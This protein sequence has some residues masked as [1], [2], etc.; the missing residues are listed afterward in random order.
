MKSEA[1]ENEQA[2]V[3][4]VRGEVALK[5]LTQRMHGTLGFWLGFIFA[6][7]PNDL[8]ALRKRLERQFSDEARRMT[9]LTPGKPA[10][11]ASLVNRLLEDRALSQADCV[12]I[13]ALTVEAP[14]AREAPWTG[15]WE[16]LIQ[17]LEAQLD[18][19][20]RTLSGPLL[21]AAPPSLIDPCPRWGPDLWSA[22]ALALRIDPQNVQRG[23]PTGPPPLPRGSQSAFQA[24]T[25]PDPDEI[26]KLARD[27]QWA[28]EWAA[29]RSSR[30]PG[31][32]RASVPGM[33]RISALPGSTFEPAPESGAINIAR[34]GAH[35]D[36]AEGFLEQGRLQDAKEAAEEAYATLRGRE[37]PEEAR[38]L[39]VLAKVEHTLGNRERAEANVQK[40]ITWRATASG[41]VPTEWYAL[42]AKLACERSDFNAAAE[43]ED[44][45]F[46]A[47]L[48]RQ[49]GDE[50]P[51]ALAEQAQ[52]L[53]RLGEARLS[54]GKA[55][56]AASAFEG[57]LLLRRRLQTEASDA[58]D[59]PLAAVVAYA[60]KRLGEAHLSAGNVVSAVSAYREAVEIDRRL[61]ARAPAN[62]D[63]RHQ[64]GDS[65][66]KFSDVLAANGDTEE[67]ARVMEEGGLVM[68]GEEKQG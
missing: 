15:A 59:A 38:A 26:A 19:V 23:S 51:E 5:R 68:A 12:W 61:L 64:L 2:A 47:L 24:V 48:A 16:D 41:D 54:A 49:Q 34:A 17:G 42:G 28:Q 43:M 13:E 65:L 3:P 20:R 10:E 11:L 67:S 14:G 6:P 25:A 9:V 29:E 50:G 30:L 66:W 63:L 58:P 45:A 52:V 1:G 39:A 27:P 18:E 22:R 46:H 56:E 40:A 4:S 36:A 53:E 33:P 62:D 44:R 55:A 7:A 32:P 31:M 57:C 37:N 60:L 35:I 8:H 21:L